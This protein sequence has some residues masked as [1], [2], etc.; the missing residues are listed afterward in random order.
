[1]LKEVEEAL[2]TFEKTG[3]SN[4]ALYCIARFVYGCNTRSPEEL[5]ML[6]EIENRIERI[7]EARGGNTP[8]AVEGIR[9]AI[10][11][12]KGSYTCSFEEKT[13]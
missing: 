6:E 1:M 10:N 8:P 3:G 7:C 11:A 9:L 5:Y 4:V 12:S 2:N 13:S